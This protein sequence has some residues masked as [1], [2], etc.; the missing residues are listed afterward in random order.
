[1]CCQYQGVYRTVTVYRA[2]T[3]NKRY[4]HIPP[5]PNSKHTHI[6]TTGETQAEWLM[7]GLLHRLTDTHD[8][9]AKAALKSCV[10]MCIPNMWVAK[11]ACYVL[12]VWALLCACALHTGL[13]SSQEAMCA[14][15]LSGTPSLP[16][17]PFFSCCS[18]FLACT[19]MPSTCPEVPY[20]PL[21][22]A[23]RQA[24]KLCSLPASRM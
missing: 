18:F 12:H 19:C 7:E 11:D 3:I 14:C 22:V 4:T 8:P 13:L 24:S 23:H 2:L 6:H 17:S 20:A 16:P 10:F 5:P 1:M 21:H 15:V 9:V